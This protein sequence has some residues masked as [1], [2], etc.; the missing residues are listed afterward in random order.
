MYNAISEILDVL[1]AVFEGYCLQYFY[2]SFLHGR[3]SKGKWSSLPAALIYG[4]FKLGLNVVLPA[5]YESIKIIA[6]QILILFALT[7]ISMCFYKAMHMIT[8]FLVI[9]FAAVSEISF[10]I[11]YA[12]LQAGSRGFAFLEWC[13]EK[14]WIKSL[15][16]FE[17]ILEMTA[18]GLYLLMLTLFGLLLYLSLRSIVKNFREKEYQIHKTELLFIVIPGMVGLLTCVLLRIIM[19]MAEDGMPRLLYERYPILI[20]LVPV[21]LVLSL[22]SILFGIKLFQNMIYL[23]RERSDR[24]ILQKQISSM[25]EHLAEM[26]HVYAG[27][28]SMKHDMKNTLS[29]IMQLAAG[30]N[31]LANG[32]KENTEL[33]EYLVEL[34]QTMNKLEFKFQTGC[35][36]VDALL[37]MK[38]HEVIRTLPELLINVDHLIFPKSLIIQSYDIGII[39]GNALDNAIEACRKLKEKDREAEIFIRLYSFQKGKMFFIEAENSFDGDVIRKEQAEFPETNKKDKEVHGIGLVNIKKVA[40]KY[41]GAVDWSVNNQIFT[42]SIMMQNERSVE[43]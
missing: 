35:S 5:N 14:G 24:V 42:L 1:H 15:E 30:N 17:M 37:T 8:I 43:K 22:L 11:A 28:R 40:E 6:R 36:V 2:G 38:Y 12:G 13:F 16:Q 3:M 32:E 23:N 33:Q 34:N 20:L 4:G 19:V 21:I 26:E 10:F 27:I 29:V 9:T 31:S 39:I 41:Y 25:Q 7:A 18:M